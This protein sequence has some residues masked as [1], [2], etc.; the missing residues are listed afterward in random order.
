MLRSFQA[1]AKRIIPPGFGP[2]PASGGIPGF[3][4]D[5]VVPPTERDFAPIV[6]PGFGPGPAIVPGFPLAA[7]FSGPLGPVVV[8][9][10]ERDFAPIVPPGFGPGPAIVPGFPLAARFSGPLGPVVVPP[11]ERDLG[12]IGTVV[13][14]LPGTAGFGPGF[15]PGPVVPPTER[16]FQIIAPVPDKFLQPTE[17]DLL[18]LG[19]VIPDFPGGP[20][21]AIPLPTLRR[22]AYYDDLD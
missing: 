15:G 10:S 6:P 7:R 13:P 19:P 12:Q 21:P 16:D 11:T 9:P 18:P 20:G 1:H 8:P 22:R 3:D 17:R 2:G 14:D 4:P 5:P